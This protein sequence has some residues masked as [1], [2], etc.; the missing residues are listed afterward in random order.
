MTDERESEAVRGRNFLK[1]S[2][3]VLL[4]PGYRLN[5]LDERGGVKSVH[6]K[7]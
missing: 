5:R 7:L 2:S 3:V 4:E 6:M 1:V